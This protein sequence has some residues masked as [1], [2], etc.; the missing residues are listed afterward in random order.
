MIAIT[1]PD[2]LTHHLDS[3]QA[4]AA[5]SSSPAT[6]AVLQTAYDAGQWQPYTPPPPQ[7]EAP[8]PDWQ[9]FRLALLQSATFRDWSE[10]LPATWREDLKLAAI[11]ANDEAL[12][13]IYDL[14]AQ[15]YPPDDEAAAEWQA[16]ADVS[17]I[18]ITF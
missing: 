6:V 4:I 2:G 15:Q 9:N 14:L 13:S 8:S 1:T 10:R 18:P 7:P 5:Y 3:P 16:I 11:A 12:Q 17:S